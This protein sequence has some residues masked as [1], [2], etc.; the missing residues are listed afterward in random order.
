[1]NLPNEDD[2]QVLDEEEFC[3]FC[4]DFTIQIKVDDELRCCTVCQEIN[5]PED[6]DDR[7]IDYYDEV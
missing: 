4:E 6:E 7:E 2:L 1:M 3:E 5:Y